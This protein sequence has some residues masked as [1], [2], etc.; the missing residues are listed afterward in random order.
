MLSIHNPATGEI[1][2]I[3]PADDAASVAAKSRL[4]RAAQTA[5]ARV[6][7]QERLACVGRFRAGVVRELESL[8]RTMTQE[9]GKPIT[10][11]RNELNGLLALSMA[12]VGQ[13]GMQARQALHSSARTT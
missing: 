7:L 2:A 1:L 6:A 8:A 5:W 4:A 3:L 12:P 13:G 10:M 11:S 9:T